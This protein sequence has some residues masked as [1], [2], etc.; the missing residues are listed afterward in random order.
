MEAQIMQKPDG[1]AAFCPDPDPLCYEGWHIDSPSAAD[2][3]IEQVLA[4]R[5]RRDL[6]IEAAETRIDEYMQKIQVAK[7]DCERR[8]SFL[9]SELDRY[10]DTAPARETK[11]QVS[12]ALPAGRLVRT[13]AK[14]EFQRAGDALLAY[15]KACAPEYVRV[16]EEVAWN[17]LKQDLA[18]TGDAAV[19]RSTG[20]VVPGITV[21]KKP[22][23]F[24]IKLK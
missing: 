12:L 9:I 11:T 4:E 5:R 21:V 6:Y 18:I 7:E 3:A 17:E 2:W 8:T 19:R 1:T 13:K 20:E 24:E 14:Q 16:K 15:V 10:L 23:S 22:A